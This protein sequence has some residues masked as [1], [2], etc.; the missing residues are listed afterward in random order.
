MNK[1]EPIRDREK[2]EEMKDELKKTGT[3]NFILFYTGINTGLRV[4]DILNL[5]FDD[6]RNFD[7]SMKT[8]ID[9][10][11]KK[12]KKNKKFPI[13]NGLLVELERY[14]KNMKPKEYLFK[15]QIGINTP[16]TYVQAYRI[17]SG[18]AKKIGLT[19][20]RYTYYEKN[21]WLSSLSTI[22]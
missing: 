19:K 20:I 14:T 18:A 15:S 17:L 4:S 3:R 6:V 16:I 11:E 10:P 9:K 5:T 8:H 13:C 22:S 21:I 7:G 12:T 2:L 1:V